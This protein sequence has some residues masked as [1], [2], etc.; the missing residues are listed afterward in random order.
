MAVYRI[1]FPRNPYNPA[2]DPGEARFSV[3]FSQD[4]DSWVCDRYL[5]ATWEKRV[6]DLGGRSQI[7]Y[8]VTSTS[9]LSLEVDAREFSFAQTWELYMRRMPKAGD[10]IKFFCELSMAPQW[11]KVVAFSCNRNNPGGTFSVKPDFR[12]KGNI[13]VPNSNVVA[14]EDREGKVRWF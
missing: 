7:V 5:G 6:V 8:T 13:R 1:T 11:G 12:H 2:G 14:V 3:E 9:G 4:P 10:R